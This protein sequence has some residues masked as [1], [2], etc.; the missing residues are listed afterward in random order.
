MTTEDHRCKDPLDDGGFPFN[1]NIILKY[2]RH[3]AKNHD[4]GKSNQMS[5]L[6]SSLPNPEESDL[7]NR[8]DNGYRSGGVNAIKFVGQEKKN[9]W[10]EVKQDF[11]G[12]KQ[13]P[14]NSLDEYTSRFRACQ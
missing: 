3:P 6:K 12:F 5:R 1:K 11:H 10:K 7:K 2:E 8:G 14:G 9:Q 13:R 4:D